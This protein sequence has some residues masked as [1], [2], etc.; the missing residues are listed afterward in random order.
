MWAPKYRFEALRGEVRLRVQEIIG[1][2]RPELGVTILNR[3]LSRDH[4]HRF[5]EIPS[6]V[7]VSNFVRRAKGRSS[8]KIQPK[9]EHIRKRY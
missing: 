5:V 4:V 1:Q 6:P 8:R 2:A 9:F 3:V 7:S